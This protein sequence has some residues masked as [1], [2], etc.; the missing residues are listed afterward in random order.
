[1][2][3]IFDIAD[4]STPQAELLGHEGPVWQVSWA[5]PKFGRLLAS[6]GFDCRVII[7]KEA[8]ANVWTQVCLVCY[9]SIALA[10]QT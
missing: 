2:L 3:Q 9:H 7:W 4:Q 6:C 1:M 8:Q 5:H 10:T